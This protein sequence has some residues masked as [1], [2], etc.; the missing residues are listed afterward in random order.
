MQSSFD[1]TNPTKE[2]IEYVDSIIEDI[3][4]LGFDWE[5]RLYYAS[6]YYDQFY[7]YAV[8]LVKK[9]LAYVD[10]LTAE[11]IREYRGTLTEPGK[12]SPYRN[13]SIEEN[14]DLF[15]RMKNGE[16]DNG[17][18]V[19][20]AKIDMASPNMN[21]RDPVI[22]RILKAPHHRT[23]DKWHISDGFAHPLEDAIE[24][25]T[26]S[27]CSNFEDHSHYMIGSLKS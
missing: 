27:L 2:D 25:I 22:Y 13:R 21:M 15:E 1:D 12:D 5:D 9:G 26:H 8:T 16:F 20:R 6:D 11:E 23:G 7:D 24:N 19:L 17:E 18:R 10:D 14:L 4:W 3:K